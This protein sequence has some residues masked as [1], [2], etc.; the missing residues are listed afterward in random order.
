MKPKKKSWQEKLADNKG[1]PKVSPITLKQS[2][3]SGAGG[4]NP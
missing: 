2:K 3:R 1:F 4:P